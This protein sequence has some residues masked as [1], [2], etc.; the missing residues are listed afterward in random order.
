MAD[1]QGFSCLL[2]KLSLLNSVLCM[3]LNINV[4]QYL[5]LLAPIQ[6]IQFLPSYLNPDLTVRLMTTLQ[7]HYKR[8]AGSVVTGL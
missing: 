2:S 6:K 5:W 7:N 8:D 4:S 1:Y 3:W